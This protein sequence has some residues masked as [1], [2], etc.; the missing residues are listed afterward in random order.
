LVDLI[1]DQFSIRHRNHSPR[2]LLSKSKTKVRR[3]FSR[4]TADAADRAAK[5]M[6]NVSWT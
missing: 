6:T 3:S 5:K 2:I 4:A 1:C